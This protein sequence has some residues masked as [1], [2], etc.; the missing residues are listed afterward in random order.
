MPTSN[1]LLNT[2]TENYL[3][4]CGAGVQYPVSCPSVSVVS[5]S[6]A[7]APMVP[8]QFPSPPETT[9]PA[10]CLPETPPPDIIR[11]GEL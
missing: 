3:E 8:A 1:V 7:L 2:P 4:D 10:K 5:V 11:G 6:C 9:V